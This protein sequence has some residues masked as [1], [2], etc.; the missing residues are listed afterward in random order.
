M[1]ENKSQQ[2]VKLIM[3]VNYGG[4]LWGANN[5]INNKLVIEQG[6][7]WCRPKDYWQ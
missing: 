4:K 2:H 3:G 5:V 6:G 7:S 1:V